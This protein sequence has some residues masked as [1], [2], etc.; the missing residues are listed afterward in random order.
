MGLSSIFAGIKKSLGLGWLLKYRGSDQNQHIWCDR[1]DHIIL[2]V[3][4]ATN[5]EVLGGKSPIYGP[6][7]LF[8]GNIKSHVRVSPIEEVWVEQLAPFSTELKP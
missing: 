8:V 3:N 6:R 5:E 2:E 1:A 7:K 4:V